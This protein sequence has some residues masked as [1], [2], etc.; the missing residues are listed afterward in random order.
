MAYAQP[1]L[2]MDLAFKIILTRFFPSQIKP[3]ILRV[4]RQNSATT[5]GFVLITNRVDLIGKFSVQFLRVDIVSFCDQHAREEP[6]QGGNGDG[7]GDG[8]RLS[9]RDGQAPG[10]TQEVHPAV[11]GQ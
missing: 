10:E 6:H 1:I 11:L 7:D 9:E 5:S 8:G 2:K 4:F 3:N